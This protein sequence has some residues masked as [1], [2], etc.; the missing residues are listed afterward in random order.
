MRGYNN[1]LA[2]KSMHRAIVILVGVNNNLPNKGGDVY[3]SNGYRR[4]CYD[5]TFETIKEDAK[6]QGNLLVTM[7][8][9]I[10]FLEKSIALR[11]VE[12][13]V[14]GRVDCLTN[15]MALFGIDEFIVVKRD[16]NRLQ[17]E[18][19]TISDKYNY[20]VEVGVWELTRVIGEIGI[21]EPI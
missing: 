18:R 7:R 2:Y 10:D 17:E 5:T 21:S 12:K 8:N 14:Y 13:G 9:W 15:P 3:Y 4:I 1:P 20:F 16:Y 11:N 6:T 19:D